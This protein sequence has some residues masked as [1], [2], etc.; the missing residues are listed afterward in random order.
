[1]R[2]HVAARL[3][4]SAVIS[5]DLRYWH[6]TDG[7]LRVFFRVPAETLRDAAG[8]PLEAVTTPSLTAA[9]SRAL[10]NIDDDAYVETCDVETPSGNAMCRCSVVALSDTVVVH[11]VL[12]RQQG[13]RF[14]VPDGYAISANPFSAAAAFLATRTPSRNPVRT[15]DSPEPH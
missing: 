8:T 7:W 3:A 14:D 6:A 12:T 11:A 4:G 5:R 1:M 13:P 10:R 9:V 15:P 2:G